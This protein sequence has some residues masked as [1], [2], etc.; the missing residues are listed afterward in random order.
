M[1]SN[2]L[3]V[4]TISCEPRSSLCYKLHLTKGV[5]STIMIHVVWSYQHL[6]DMRAGT[7]SGC[8]WDDQRSLR[9]NHACSW[10][11]A[12]EQLAVVSWAAWRF[13]GLV[14]ETVR[15][16]GLFCGGQLCATFGSVMPLGMPSFWEVKVTG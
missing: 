15:V 12:V 11:L 5:S 16:L 2:L 3:F 13:G 14:L 8:N 1:V 4:S 7:T 6:P 10:Q 9:G